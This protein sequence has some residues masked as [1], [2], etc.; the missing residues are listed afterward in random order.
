MKLLYAPTSAY[1]RKVMVVAHETGQVDDIE[2]VFTTASPVTPNE[3]LNRANP[4]GKIPALVVD[5]ETLFDSRVICEFLDARSSGVKVFPAGGKARWRALT[6]QA[7]GDGLIDAALGARY[8]ALMRPAERQWQGWRD[9]Q[10]AKVH[11]AVA[12][13]ADNVPS[14]LTIGAIACGCALGY[15]DFRY[16]EIDWR[17]PHPLLA[18][19]FAAFSE[20]PSMKMTVPM[21]A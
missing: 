12:S 4:L 18:D 11:R 2:I 6:Q 10:L 5:G 15:L 13:M 1:T 17:S 20:R 21:D 19:W 8:E 7:L 9:A 14:N 3:D 16:P